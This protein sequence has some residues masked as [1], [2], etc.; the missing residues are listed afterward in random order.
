[1]R[2]TKLVADRKR[3][4][5]QSMSRS[6][7]TPPR[8]H[9]SRYANRC[10]RAERRTAHNRDAAAKRRERNMTYAERLL[11]PSRNR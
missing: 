9:W 7:I 5:E 8:D 1:M 6:K 10:G 11:G 3:S 2:Y 4:Q